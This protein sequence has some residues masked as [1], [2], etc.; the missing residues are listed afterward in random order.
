MPKKDLV[1]A[2]TIEDIQGM[3][4][5]MEN[6]IVAKVGEKVESIASSLA[7]L[8]S[9]IDTIE[10][11]LQQVKKSCDTNFDL[12][13]KEINEIE[14]KRLNIVIFLWYLGCLRPRPR[15][16]PLLVIWT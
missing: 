5:Q 10:S 15:I 14:E 7:T 8:G 12:T 1:Y 3:M 11:G 4:N 6:R 13:L 2:L 16:D 9:R